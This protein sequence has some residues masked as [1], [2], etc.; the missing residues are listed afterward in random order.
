MDF[1]QYC[2]IANLSQGEGKSLLRLECPERR[3]TKDATIP[4]ADIYRVLLEDLKDPNRYLEVVRNRI[5]NQFPNEPIL[6]TG[7]TGQGFALRDPE[8]QQEF[9]TSHCRGA[10]SCLFDA[11]KAEKNKERVF[12]SA[13]DEIRSDERSLVPMP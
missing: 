13:I 10:L 2:P 7:A 5:R 3:E 8:L 11:W 12:Q 6:S 1:Q 9:C 4:L